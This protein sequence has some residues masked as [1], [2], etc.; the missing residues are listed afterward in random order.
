MADIE[1]SGLH[2]S[3]LVC[4]HVVL[5]FSRFFI[6]KTVIFLIKHTLN[7]KGY[8]SQMELIMIKNSYDTADK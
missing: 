4:A 7:M 8:P 6:F 1:N 3:E 5:K 2:I